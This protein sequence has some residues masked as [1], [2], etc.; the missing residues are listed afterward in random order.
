SGPGPSGRV[1]LRG[2]LPQVA[3]L[4]ERDGLSSR[5]PRPSV[6]DPP[7][8]HFPRHERSTDGSLALQKGVRL[9]GSRRSQRLSRNTD[10]HFV[11]REPGARRPPEPRGAKPFS[12]PLI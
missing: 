6:S 9:A 1:L 3:V 7:A 8:D 2:Q 12:G 10:G 11:S 5:P 4:S